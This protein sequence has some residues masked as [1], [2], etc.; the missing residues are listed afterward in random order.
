MRKLE[1]IFL[2]YGI[3]LSVIPFVYAVID[4]LSGLG[5]YVFEDPLRSLVQ[6]PANLLIYVSIPYFVFYFIRNRLDKKKSK[7][8]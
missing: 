7:R 1:I 8:L 6:I 3:G 2:T 4:P 5:L